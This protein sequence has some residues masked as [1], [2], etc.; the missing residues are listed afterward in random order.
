MLRKFGILAVLALTFHL[1]LLSAAEKTIAGMSFSTPENWKETEPSSSMRKFQFEIPGKSKTA[2][3]AVFYFGENQ[4]GDVKSNIERWKSQFTKLDK[5]ETNEKAA[6]G[7]KVTQTT[8]EGSFQLTMGPMMAAHGKPA[9]N[10][11]VLG[12]IVEAPEGS[13]FFKMTGPKETLDGAKESFSSLINSV[14]KT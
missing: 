13:V 3:L 9:D 7:M 10:Y 8:L 4:G 2:E 1:P 11:S 12:A 6:G 5:E 14:K